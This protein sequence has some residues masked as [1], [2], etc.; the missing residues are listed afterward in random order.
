MI[1]SK[2]NYIFGTQHGDFLYNSYTNNLMRV[3]HDFLELAELCKK[4]KYPQVS[5]ETIAFLNQHHILEDDDF[6]LYRQIKAE[7]L[8]SR[9][10]TQYLSLTIAPTTACNFKCIYCY[11]AGVTTDTVKDKTTSIGDVI[12]FVK[13]FKSSKYLRVTWYGGEPLLMFGYIESLSYKFK[14]MFANY[15]AYMITNGYLLDKSKVEKLRALNIKGLQITIDG[16]E[17]T[18][19]KRRPHKVNTDSFKRIISNLDYLFKIYPEVYISFR[20]NIDKTNEDEYHDIY[21]FLEDKFGKYNIKTHPGYVTDEFS[22]EPNHCCLLHDEINN[23]VIQQ[24][25]NYHIPISLYPSSSFGECCARHMT[26]FVI[27]PRGELYKCWN[28]IGIADKAIGNIKDFS[29]SDKNVVR[30]L[31]DND[32]LESEEC[33]YCFCFPI[34]N[35]GCPY[36]RIYHPDKQ[37]VF[38]NAKRESIKAFLPRYVDYKIN[39][40]KK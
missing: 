40:I 9:Y 27:G 5:T 19:N 16:L 37:K 12:S 29:L 38:C 21:N 25:D 24:Y 34:C 7:R 39:L 32:P 35:G 26:S 30:Y 15:S 20:V 11:E 17:T 31:L 23:F 36:S 6:D 10:N 13:S 8:A 22:S 18:H 28:D 4:G 33:K 3:S 2:Y 14:E 1:W